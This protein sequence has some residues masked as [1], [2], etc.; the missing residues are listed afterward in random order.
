LRPQVRRLFLGHLSHGLLVYI[1]FACG[2]LASRNVLF[3]FLHAQT[4]LFGGRG[5]GCSGCC[6]WSSSCSNACGSGSSGGGSSRSLCFCLPP[7]LL[8][9]QQQALLFGLR[10]FPGGLLGIRVSL[11]FSIALFVSRC[12]LRRW[13]RLLL[14]R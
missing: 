14:R 10:T 9:L 1:D 7:C 12:I 8:F 3:L 11:F 4:L 13:L 5:G 2:F 6:G